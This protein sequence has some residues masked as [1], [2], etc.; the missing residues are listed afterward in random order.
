MAARFPRWIPEGSAPVTL[1]GSPAVVYQ[2][3]RVGAPYA[4]GYVGESSKP[5]FNYRFRSPEQRAEYVSKFLANQKA[6]AESKAARKAARLA[7]LRAFVPSL[8]A[9]EVLE[10]SW[11]YDQTNTHFFKVLEVKGKR[12]LIQELAHQSVPGSQ[13]FMSE[14]VMPGEQLV[15]EASWRPVMV[16]DRVNHPKGYC[17]LYRWD[18]KPNYSSWYA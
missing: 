8:K 7:E 16:G 18:G 17:A 2:Q 11:G 4:I 15:G 1:E 6:I 10:G 3:E 9:G 13:G 14:R 12:A 5:A